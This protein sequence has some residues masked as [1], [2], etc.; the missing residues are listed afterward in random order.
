MDVFLTDED[1]ELLH[2]KSRTKNHLQ[3]MINSI[4]LVESSSD[5]LDAL[6]KLEDKSKDGD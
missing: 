4:K 6:N 1:K 2:R 5:T 3:E